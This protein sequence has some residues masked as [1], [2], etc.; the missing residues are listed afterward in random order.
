MDLLSIHMKNMGLKKVCPVKRRK[1]GKCGRQNAGTAE[2]A[3]DPWKLKPG[4]INRV[5]VAVIFEAEM[6]LE[7]AFLEPLNL[8]PLKP[9]Y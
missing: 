4:F 8:R 1:Y 7:I 9:H 3:D 5:L 2:N 6:P